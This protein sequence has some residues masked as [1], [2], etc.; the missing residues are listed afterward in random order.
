MRHAYYNTARQSQIDDTNI[1][2]AKRDLDF[3]LKTGQ[4]V[5]MEARIILR[6]LGA[7]EPEINEF[8][9]QY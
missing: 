6:D 5:K 9:D 3:Q 7:F 1:S 2:R 8:L 4:T